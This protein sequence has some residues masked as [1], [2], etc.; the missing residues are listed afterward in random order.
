[1][2]IFVNGQEK[3]VFVNGKQMAG[4]V[5]GVKMFGSAPQMDITDPAIIDK[6]KAVIE[7]N[8]SV[9]ATYNY[10]STPVMTTVSGACVCASNNI[11]CMIPY[12]GTAFTN[13]NT[14]TQTYQTWGSVL[15]GSVFACLGKN[16]KVYFTNGLSIYEADP[17]ERTAHIAGTLNNTALGC[18]LGRNGKIYFGGYGAAGEYVQTAEF[19]P[20]TKSVEYFGVPI[21]VAG[22]C[23]AHNGKIYAVMRLGT[24]VVEIDT[25]TKTTTLFGNLAAGNVRNIVYSPATRKIYAI[26]GFVPNPIQE[27]DV[28]NHTTKAVSPI[29]SSTISTAVMQPDGKIL[30]F[31]FGTNAV[32]VF[33]PETYQLTQRSLTAPTGFASVLSQDNSIVAT[34]NEVAARVLVPDKPLELFPPECYLSPF[35]NTGN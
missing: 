35:L 24:Q 18:S 3:K 8:K 21:N 11:V 30:I 31:G 17:V 5:N 26:P 9:G 32:A 2:P 29:I 4:Y 27:I 33:D 25:D 1:M 28:D 14:E 10:R 13:Y 23:M 6:I 19:D 20:V 7:R 15:G 16:G 34:G 12:S 22:M